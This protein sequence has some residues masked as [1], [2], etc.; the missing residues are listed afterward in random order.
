MIFRGRIF[1]NSTVC[2]KEQIINWCFLFQPD[3]Q[4]VYDD[5]EAGDI[6]DEEVGI[7]PEDVYDD[8]EIGQEVYNELEEDMPPPIPAA[9]R[10]SL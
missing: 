6:Y 9:P 2:I 5:G 8:G 10:V 1:I 7:G 4:E 3:D